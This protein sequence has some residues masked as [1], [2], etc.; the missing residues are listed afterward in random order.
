[1]KDGKPEFKFK[2]RNG[3]W[4]CTGSL[5]S[6]VEPGKWYYF[7]VT[8]DAEGLITGYLNGKQCFQKLYKPGSLVTNE[9]PAYIG[10]GES[11]YGG[12]IGYPFSGLIDQ[13][14]IS[15]GVHPPRAEKIAEF[16]RLSELY[17]E[18]ADKAKKIKRQEYIKTIKASSLSNGN[19]SQMTMSE[20]KV[21]AERVKYNHFFRKNSNGGKMIVSV[22]PTASRVLRVNDYV[23]GKDQT[24]KQSSYLRG[25]Q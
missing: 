2:E 5:K 1:M 10:A 22:L 24:E 9:Q 14:N 15:S 20:L 17:M 4:I 16:K 3:N 12:G 19:L 25:A 21:L 11:Y 6:L 8:M 7:T 18:K 23:S 13:V